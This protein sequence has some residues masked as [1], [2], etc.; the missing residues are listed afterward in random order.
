MSRTK[1]ARGIERRGRRADRRTPGQPKRLCSYF[2]S[3]NKDQC[4]RYPSLQP[5][6]L[7]RL[8]SKATLAE[9]REAAYFHDPEDWEADEADKMVF[10]APPEEAAFVPSE[11][12]PDFGL[13]CF[14]S[15]GFGGEQEWRR[16]DRDDC[17]NWND[18]DPEGWEHLGTPEDDAYW[19]AHQKEDQID[20]LWDEHADWEYDAALQER[21]EAEELEP[22]ANWPW[23]P[24]EPGPPWGWAGPPGARLAG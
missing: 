5:S 18:G 2:R 1:H 19:A 16:P 17:W 6:Y 11:S 4:G 12:L 14:T 10:R 20:W 15:D 8:A 13:S 22:E 21:R 9:E 7:A 23:G 3:G 24:W